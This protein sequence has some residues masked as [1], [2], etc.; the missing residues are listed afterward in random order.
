MNEKIEIVDITPDLAAEW[1]TK[2]THNRHSRPRTVNAYAADMLAGAWR[3][4]GESIKFAK[5]G[6]LLDGQHRLLAIVQSGVTVRMVVVWDLDD[7][8][9]ETMDGGTKRKFSDALTLRGERNASVLGAVIRFVHLWES[10]QRKMGSA[11][12][13]P[14]NNQLFGTLDKYPWLRDSIPTINKASKS[15]IPGSV[16]GLTYWLFS[17]IDSGDAEFFFDRLGDGQNLQKGDPIYELRRCIEA[18]RSARGTRS[19]TYMTAVTIKAW[20]AYRDGNQIGV[21]R[22][23]VG[24]ASPEKFPEPH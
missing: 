9:Q 1:L 16:V 11:T 23:I 19:L 6:K 22:Y 17:Q 14:T 10:G 18:G 12:F 2:N 3:W 15:G 24:G 20:N 13:A 7:E 8:T 21:L 4:N 5:D